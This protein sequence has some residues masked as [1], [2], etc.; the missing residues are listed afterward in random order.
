MVIGAEIDDGVLFK[1][2]VLI[3]GKADLFGHQQ[4]ADDK[5]LGDDELEDRGRFADPGRPGLAGRRKGLVLEYE[6]GFE[7]GKHDGGI[8]TGE[9]GDGEHE[10]D[11]ESD[12]LGLMEEIEMK[13]FGDEIG[14]D[15]QEK[16][17]QDDREDRGHAGEDE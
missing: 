5:D 7:A 10:D 13:I 2:E 11:Q 6:D 4:G 12:D 1:P 16:G 3:D 9:H 15:L 8:D 17:G 14:E